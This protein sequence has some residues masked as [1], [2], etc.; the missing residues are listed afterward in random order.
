MNIHEY[1]AKEIL[2]RHGV[3]VPR[4]KVAFS[5]PEAEAAASSLG[6]GPFVV[7]AQIHAGGRGKGG[8][9]RKARDL[10]EIRKIGREMF[11]MNLV[12]PQTGPQ[13]KPVN[14]ILV[15]E[16]LPVV[17]EFYL[18]ITIDRRT[19]RVAI[20]GSAAGGMDIEEVVA[21]TP[22]KIH[23]I[24][25]EPS[26]GFTFFQGRKIALGMGL[27]G[28]LIG[29][30]AAMAAGLYRAFWEND[31]TLT[32]VNPLVL[33][34]RGELMA[35][36]A[37]MNLDDNALYRHPEILSLRDP[38]QED[39]RDVE[40]ARL[41]LHTYVNLTGNIG[42]IVNGAGLGMATLDLLRHYGGEA[43]NFLDAG[44]GASKEVIQNAF[45]L[46]NSNPKVKGI[47]INM[48]GGITRCDSYAQGVVDAL[49]E[50]PLRVPLVIRMEGT[51][52]E[53]G[54]K[55][56]AESGLEIVYAVHM[57]EAAQKIIA[58]AQNEVTR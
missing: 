58:L 39:P 19:G 4:G 30:G 29:E 23:T 32:E 37:K 26:C 3:K 43:A 1:Q 34:A 49:R 28:A 24:L 27:E 35:L 33:T 11:G 15:E 16:A 21:R 53:L 17:R 44:A 20:M 42:C 55:I 36:D 6:P 50:K 52:V 51:N 18:G 9:I 31:C 12:T 46:L 2:A 22:E 7:K 48:F 10:A 57:R 40:A 5:L 47:L 25:M 41:G 56:L 14:R 45:T 13:G 38:E 54:R 8:G